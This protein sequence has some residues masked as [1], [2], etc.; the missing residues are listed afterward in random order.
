MLLRLILSKELRESLPGDLE[1]EYRTEILPKFGP[2]CAR[3][4]YRKQVLA[5]MLPLVFGR[6][7]KATV[8]VVMGKLAAWVLRKFTG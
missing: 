1:E 2:G 4:W 5:S 3:W 6:L 8:I 7:A